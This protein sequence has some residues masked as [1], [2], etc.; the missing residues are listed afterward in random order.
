MEL[1]YLEF[2]YSEDDEGTGTFDAMASVAHAQV[3]ALYA[4]VSSVL[5]W[6][7]SQ[8]PDTCAAQE[9]GGQWQYDLQGV[10]EQTTPLVLDFDVDV[11]V[12]DACLRSITG[13]PA[14]V[15]TVVTLSISGS[16]QVCGA[17]REAFGID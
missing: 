14:A 1:H 8:F 12:D 11:D 4:E 13:A 9:D 15:R 16:A 2:D 17:L 5:A 3:A 7:H 6:A 10:Q